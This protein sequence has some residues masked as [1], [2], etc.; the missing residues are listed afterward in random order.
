MRAVWTFWSKPYFACRGFCWREHVHHFL[1]W[2]LSL[3]L[4]RR[5]YPDTVLVTDCAGEKLLIDQLGLSFAHV[6]TE[7]ERLRKA[8]AG[9]WTLGKL[10]SYTLQDQPFIHLDTDVFLWKPLPAN[11]AN[12]PVFAQCPEEH[13]VDEWCGPGDI[14]HAFARHGL[15]LPDEWEW[16]RSRFPN[17]FREENC[18]ILGATRVDFIR[19]YAKVAIDLVMN[20]DHAAAWAQFSDKAGYNPVLE[21]FLLAACLD[22]HRFHPTSP[23]RGI[24]IRYLFSSSGEAFD[25]QAAGRLGFTHL[26]GRAKSSAPVM[27]RLEQRV[28][29]EDMAFYEHCVQLSRN[30]HL[31]A[32]AGG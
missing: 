6:S 17:H 30:R 21:Q 32:A 22:F 8:D 3:R 20:P 7:L 28:Q 23:F 14:E 13:R 11:V 9:W 16:S 27:Q 18:G 26:I 25:P 1:A 12:G 19:Y 4:A 24:G 15:T 31:F 10:W 5:H 29:H 2:G